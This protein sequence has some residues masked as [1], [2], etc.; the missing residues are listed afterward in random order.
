MSKNK[1]QNGDML[2]NSS[3]EKADTKSDAPKS[4]VP[5]FSVSDLAFSLKK[6]LEDNFGRVRVRGELSRVSIPASGHM[7]SSLKDDGAVIDA[8]CWKGVLSKISIK[9][10]E[11]MEVIC[12][13]RIS[14]YPQRSNY[15]L[16]IERMELAGEGALLKLLEDR[17]KKLAAEGLF[18]KE[19]KRKLPYLPKVIG[20]ITSP[21]GAV[22]RDIIHRLDDRFPRHVILW[23]TL[24]QGENASDQIAAAIHG[25]QTLNQHGMPKPDLLILA[26]GGGSLEDL[27]PFNEENVV[28]AIANS[29]IPVISAV[30]HETD[31]TLSDY[32]A[33]M[34]APTPTGAAE[35]AVP[36][37]RDL[38]AYTLETQS[39]MVTAISRG[40]TERHNKTGTLKARLGDPA[41]LLETKTQHIDHS[42]SKMLHAY[43]HLLNK[44]SERTI[45]ISGRLLRPKDQILKA[46]NR[47]NTSA[48]KLENIITIIQRERHNK[49]NNAASRLRK[50]D[51]KNTQQS[52]G[53][54][55]DRLKDTKIKMFEPYK[56]RV[57]QLDKLLQAYSYENVLKRG[58]TVIQ[59]EKGHLISDG[60]NIKTGQILNIKFR[61]KHIIKA[62]TQSKNAAPK[63]DKVSENTENKKQNT[64]K[65]KPQQASLF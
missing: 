14:T 26:R 16:I 45:Q 22:I 1:T 12:T 55:A 18:A 52:L 41:R 19:R 44:K 5:E 56:I 31:T 42:A 4:N 25:F 23:P 61:D 9:P 6:T 15:Q 35:I 49:I 21:T 62:I 32:A 59:D 29:C 28:R 40:M 39:R 30:G 3:S 54:A 11:G 36:V 50:P 27:M 37:R 58:F 33:D 8:V 24:V 64:S 13:G 57:K 7:Y 20:V 65:Q 60:K 48:Q 10:E 2:S 46:E 53:R 51:Y 38:M 47:L 43:R 17:K 63:K 34:R